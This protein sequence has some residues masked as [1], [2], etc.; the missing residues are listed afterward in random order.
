MC[1]Y[2][3][4]YGNDFQVFL[5]DVFYLYV[6]WWSFAVK[7]FWAFWN[8]VYEFVCV[9]TT[10][11]MVMLL[12]DFGPYGTIFMKMCVHCFILDGQFSGNYIFV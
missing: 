7:G 2:N 10:V 11:A 12:W 9:A 6:G 3:R 5:A 8:I 4:C 1:C